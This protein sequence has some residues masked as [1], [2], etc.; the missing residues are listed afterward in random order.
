MILPESHV[1]TLEDAKQEKINQ[2][3][4]YDNSKNV[5]SFTVVLGED[6]AIEHWLTPD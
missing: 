1:R 6:N 4:E 2:I 5:N 3:E